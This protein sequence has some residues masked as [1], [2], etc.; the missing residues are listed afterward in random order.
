MFDVQLQ[1]VCT[2]PRLETH[3]VRRSARFKRHQEI[4][5]KELNID[6]YDLNSCYI[7]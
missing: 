7:N 6:Q 3:F 5:R 2:G 4:N 1:M